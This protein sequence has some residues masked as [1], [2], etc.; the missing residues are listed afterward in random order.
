MTVWYTS[1]H[2]IGHRAMAWMRKHGEWPQDRSLITPE[3]VDWHDD[4]LADAWDSVVK[5]DDVVWVLGD[6]VA[7][8]SSVKRGLAWMRDRPGTK[9]FILGNHDSAHPMHKDANKWLPVYWGLDLPKEHRPFKT[10]AQSAR[11]VLTMHDGSKQDVVLSHFPYTGDGMKEERAAQWRLRDEGLPI[12]HGH[13]HS[14]ERVTYDTDTLVTSFRGAVRQ[15]HVGVDA[16]DFKP[17]SQQQIIELLEAPDPWLTSSIGLS[18]VGE[19]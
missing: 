8:S 15:I 2:H 1:D 6:L 17:V 18:R 16:W 10:V 13:V 19:V 4:M 7:N 3:L 9:H 5:K 11:R 14:A 12:L